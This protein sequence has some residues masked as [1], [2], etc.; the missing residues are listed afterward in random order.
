MVT[1]TSPITAANLA[2][3]TGAHAPSLA[4]LLQTLVTLGLCGRDDAGGVYL[5][6]LGKAMRSDVADSARSFVL[7]ITAP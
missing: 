6:P 2:E 7:F 3:E 5:T 1:S 4:R